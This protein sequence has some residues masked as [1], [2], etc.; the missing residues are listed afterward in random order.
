[1][2]CPE[3]GELGPDLN[4]FSGTRIRKWVD[5]DRFNRGEDYRRSAHAQCD[6]N[7]GDTRQARRAPE[8]AKS[9][10]DIAQNRH[11]R[12]IF[13]VFACRVVPRAAARFM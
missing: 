9:E 4:Q 6:R 11:D 8:K 13:Q 5:Q 1:M 2:R 7:Q 3:P 12:S 10:F